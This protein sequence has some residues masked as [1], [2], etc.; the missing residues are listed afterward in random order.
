MNGAGEWIGAPIRSDCLVMNIGDMMEVLSNGCFLAKTHR[1][2]NILGDRYFSTLY[3]TYDYDTL[4]QALVP[5]EAHQQPS[6]Y[7]ALCCGGH[8]C[9]QIIQIFRYLQERLAEG[10]SPLSD[11]PLGLSS[12]DC[13]GSASAPNAC[14]NDAAGTDK[15]CLQ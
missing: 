10:A 7:S 6:K 13:R 3:C 11:A 2:G 5:V 9:A 8:L 12:F 15:E 1:V 4:I 14:S